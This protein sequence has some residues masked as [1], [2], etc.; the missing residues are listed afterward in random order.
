MFRG[1]YGWDAWLELTYHW[2]KKTKSQLGSAESQIKLH[3]DTLSNARIKQH[4]YH[5][6]TTPCQVCPLPPAIERWH[7]MREAIRQNSHSFV[8]Q[9]ISIRRWTTSTRLEFPR[10]TYPRGEYNLIRFDGNELRNTLL[11]VPLSQLVEL[12]LIVG[13]MSPRRLKG[14]RRAHSSGCMI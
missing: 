2:L 5:T 8:P 13:W 4:E 12:P 10:L 9:M 11:A 6:Q 7:A 3:W 14:M 1:E